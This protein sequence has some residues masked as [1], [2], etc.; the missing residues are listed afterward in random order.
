MTWIANCWKGGCC[1]S[2]YL[3]VHSIVTSGCGASG[4]P[5]RSVM[6]AQLVVSTCV[7]YFLF[8]RCYCLALARGALLKVRPS[9]GCDRPRARTRP[10]TFQAY[11]MRFETGGF[12]GRNW[13]VF[14]GKFA[15]FQGED[16]RIFKGRACTFAKRLE[17]RG[18]RARAVGR[19]LAAGALSTGRPA[20]ARAAIPVGELLARSAGLLAS[21]HT[22]SSPYIFIL[23]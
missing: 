5:S 6:G 12:Q 4:A 19:N 15:H 21:A 20:Q 3:Q 17:R 8:R 13:S 10:P 16:L 9:Q 11:V 1:V 18:S 23:L 22:S 7:V 2:G 14:K